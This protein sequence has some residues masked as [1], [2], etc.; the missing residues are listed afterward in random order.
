MA[1]SKKPETTPGFTLPET[2]IAATVPTPQPQQLSVEQA[3]ALAG[4]HQQ[5]GRLLPAE[6]ILRKVLA[7][8]P[9]N[10]HAYHLLGIV[11]HQAGKPELAIQLIEKAVSIDTSVALYFT[12]LGEMCRQ[13]GRV[14]DAI[15]HGEKAV[16]LEATHAA[17]LSNLGIAYFDAGRLEEAE[18]CQ[19]KAL[20]EN[21]NLVPALNNIGS[22]VRERKEFEAAAEYYRR[23]IDVEPNAID[24]LNN[25]GV[26]LNRLD[27]PEEA[28][29]LLDRALSVKPDFAE[30]LCNKGFA[31]DKLDRYAE[32]LECF[33]KALNIRAEYPE[34]Y[35]GVGRVRRSLHQLDI[36]EEMIRKAIAMKPDLTEAHS[37]LGSVL[38]EQGRSKDA[39]ECYNTALAIE[40]DCVSAMSGI[41]NLKLEAG[42]LA[43]SEQIFR[44]LLDKE[45]SDRASVLFSLI[46][47][48]KTKQDDPEFALLQEEEKTLSSLPE[49]KRIYAHFA[50]GKAYD[51]LGEADKAFPHF[52]E[53][54]RL[55]RSKVDYDPALHKQNF[56]NIKKVFTKTFLDRWRGQGDDS[57]VPIL[58]VGMPRSGTTLTEQIIASHPN[59]FGAG[60]LYDLMDLVGWRSAGD[61]SNYPQRMTHTNANEL[62]KLGAQYAAGLAARAPGM[63]H[64]TDKMPANFLQIGLVHLILPNAKI[65]HVARHP[66]DTCLSCYTRL[67]AH[68]QDNTYDLF[69]LGDYYRTYR[70]LMDHWHSVLPTGAFYDLR[71]EKLV[72]NT[73]EEARR[74]IDYCGLPWD[75][76]CLAFYENKRAVRTASVTQV[77]QPVYRS[78]LARWKKYEKF[79][80]PLIEGLGDALDREDGR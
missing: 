48:K 73:E 9:E 8:Q 75:D 80:G 24:P 4:Q 11:A 76:A 31:L 26:T 55:K 40:P 57:H 66:L 16:A 65:V 29:V 25:L 21:P 70:D 49:S 7:A 14:D 28:I 60:E 47:A 32:A 44:D 56:E 68:N 19:Q 78:S 17:A 1:D 43:E 35:L 10:A 51:D 13:S 58:V 37:L 69:E 71:Y 61:D 63:A 54:C 3:L 50:L 38:M 79:L 22:I 33:A 67:F 30:A 34:A 74:L 77:R 62:Q 39:E 45:E 53:G 42:D 18:D 27:R 20:A 41:G 15:A 52:M 23:A 72:E 59:V 12:N 46:N 2:P 5:S 36:A 64:V 6:D